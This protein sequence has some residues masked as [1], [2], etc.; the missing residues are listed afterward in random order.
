MVKIDKKWKKIG[1]IMKNTKE[2]DVE[3]ILIVPMEDWN[4]S[5]LSPKR[6]EI[7]KILKSR[8]VSSEMELAKLLICV[9]QIVNYCYFATTL[10]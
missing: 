4:P 10:L 6:K 8:E 5:V 7:I 9:I 3:N 2:L 1:E